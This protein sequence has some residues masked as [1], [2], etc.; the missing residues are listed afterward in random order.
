M[1]KTLEVSLTCPGGIGSANLD[2]AEM[3]FA[4]EDLEGEEDTA[5]DFSDTRHSTLPLLE[6]SVSRPLR[7]GK[8]RSNE[9]F[10]SLRPSSLP[11]PSHIRPMRGQPHIDS[12]QVILPRPKVLTTTAGGSLSPSLQYGSLPGTPSEHDAELL[13]LVAA[14]TPSHRGAWT[15]SSKA[16]QTFTRRQENL[17]C[18]RIPEEGEDT[19]EMNFA[20]QRRPVVTEDQLTDDGTCSHLPALSILTNRM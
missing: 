19:E 16:W 20:V 6:P 1:S 3:V 11:N 17:G 2:V 15:P 14:Y 18:S 10:S 9:A 5:G 8:M 13:R 4:L 12:S 7:P